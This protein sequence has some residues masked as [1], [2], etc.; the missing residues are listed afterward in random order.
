MLKRHN[1]YRQK[2]NASPLELT[3]E[4]YVVLV[5]L[6]FQ[7]NMLKPINIPP[8]QLNKRAQNFADHLAKI[9]LLKHGADKLDG[10]GPVGENLASGSLTAT[11]AVDLWYNEV[12]IY[13]MNP[14]GFHMN[15]GHFTQVSAK[16]STG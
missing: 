5:I 14:G 9:N 4:V 6:I 16:H 3:S 10:K 15:T 1:E 12:D 7:R 2:H 11:K 8:L 13:K